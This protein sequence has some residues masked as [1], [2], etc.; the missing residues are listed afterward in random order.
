MTVGAQ[1]ARVAK[2]QSKRGGYKI[3]G[4][5]EVDRAAYSA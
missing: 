3:T 5:R 4:T 1:K 2:G